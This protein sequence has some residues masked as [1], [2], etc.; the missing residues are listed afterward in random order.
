MARDG[1]GKGKVVPD[2]PKND[3]F[4]FFL[5]SCQLPKIKRKEKKRKEK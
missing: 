4:H 5:L 1:G 3:S 2:P